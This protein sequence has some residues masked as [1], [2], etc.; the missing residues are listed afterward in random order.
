MKNI[1]KVTSYHTV[2]IRRKIYCVVHEVSNL[3]MTRNTLKKH[4]CF[5]L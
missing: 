5:L 4:D 1:N 2:R 3:K